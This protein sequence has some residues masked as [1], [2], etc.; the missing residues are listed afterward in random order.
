MA[1]R[2]VVSSQALSQTTRNTRSPLIQFTG[3][4]FSADDADFITL[5]DA[6]LEFHAGP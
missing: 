1:L 6:Q 4:G 2:L 3:S 5:E